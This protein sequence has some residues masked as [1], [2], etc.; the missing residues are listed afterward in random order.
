MRRRSLLA[1]RRRRRRRPRATN[2]TTVDLNNETRPLSMW[3]HKYYIDNLT[4]TGFPVWRK[5]PSHLSEAEAE[6]LE[7]RRAL[8]PPQ[9]AFSLPPR[10]HRGPPGPCICLQWKDGEQHCI[11]L[12]HTLSGALASVNSGRTVYSTCCR[13]CGGSTQCVSLMYLVT[14]GLTAVTTRGEAHCTCVCVRVRVCLLL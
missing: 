7:R 5:L 9:H 13:C 3:L 2:A 6:V 8:P 11:Y 1:R 4:F 12:E 14:A 10:L